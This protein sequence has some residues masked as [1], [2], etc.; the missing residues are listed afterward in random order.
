MKGWMTGFHSSEDSRE[1][2]AERGGCV[3]T[4]QHLPVSERATGKLEKD[5]SSGT[6][7]TRQGELVQT[8]RVEV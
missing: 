1:V 8:E 6:A 2:R 3:E 7:V 5:N 4:S